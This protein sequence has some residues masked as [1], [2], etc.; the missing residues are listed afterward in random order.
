M[1]PLVATVGYCAKHDCVVVFFF[2]SLLVLLLYKNS[3]PRKIT[4]ATSQ[5]KE[6]RD[7]KSRQ[8]RARTT[9]LQGTPRSH[10]RKDTE[11]LFERTLIY[12]Q[13]AGRRI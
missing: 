7:R 2:L 12:Q 5:K 13:H 6:G 8:V 4:E 1:C 11:V 3:H 9:K 10:A